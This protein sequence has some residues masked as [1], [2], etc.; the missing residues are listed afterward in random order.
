MRDV[1]QQVTG[2]V[3]KLGPYKKETSPDSPQEDPLLALADKARELGI[4]VVEN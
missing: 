2:R 1:I 3:Y 4:P